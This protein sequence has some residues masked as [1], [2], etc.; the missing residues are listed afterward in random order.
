MANAFALFLALLAPLAAQPDRHGL[1]ACSG[2]DRELAV[3]HGFI[4]CH[5]GSLKTPV[6]TVHELSTS[7]LASPASRRLHFRR[8]DTLSWPGASNADYRNT[9]FSRGHLMPA[10]DVALDEQALR[11]SF[12]LSN[13]VPQTIR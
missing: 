11:D 12:L 3:K 5:S 1:P 4:V 6:W 7:R 10:R 13:A 9:S 2:Q 8:G